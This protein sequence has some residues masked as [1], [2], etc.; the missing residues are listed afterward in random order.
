MTL[1]SIIVLVFENVDF[2]LHGMTNMTPKTKFFANQLYLN[3]DQGIQEW[4][5]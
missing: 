2:L 1:I 3:M 4:T 5:M